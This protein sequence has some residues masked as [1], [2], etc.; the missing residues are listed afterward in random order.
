MWKYARTEEFGRRLLCVVL[1]LSVPLAAPGADA[2]LQREDLSEEAQRLLPKRDMVKVTFTDGEVIIGAI[3]EE[4]PENV[5][6]EETSPS[7]TRRREY[8]RSEIRTIEAMAIADYFAK[9][10]ARLRL[11]PKSS[12]SSAQYERAIRLLEEFLR[13]TP[14]HVYA[15][16]ARARLTAFQQ[17]KVNLD[18]GLKKIDGAWLAPVQAAVKRFDAFTARMGEMEKKFNGIA[19][20]NY[21][22]NAKAKQYY[23]RLIQERRDVARQL[24]E[25]INNRLPQLLASGNFDEAV[26]EAETFQKFWLG[27]VVQTEGG[28][29]T[30]RP[31][32]GRWGVPRGGQRTGALQDMDLD[33][34][35]RL[36]KRIMDAYVAAEAATPAAPPPVT[37]TNMVYIPGGYFLMGDAGASLG[38]DTHP[39]H[40]VHVAPF[41]IDA[42]EVSNAEY[43][44][45]VDHVKRTGDSSMEHPDA[46]PLK[47]HEPEGWRNSGLKQDDQPVVGADWFDAYVY[48]KWKGKR[49][50]TEAE[51]EMAARGKDG[52]RYAWGDQPPAKVFASTQSGRAALAAEI[53]R[54]EMPRDRNQKRDQPPP[55]VR[56]PDVA[57][58]VRARVP[59]RADMIDL[60]FAKEAKNAHGLHHM[61]GNA[62]EWLA[63][64]YQSD[65]Y[66]Q[67]PIQNPP[68][69]EK[70]NGHLIR[71]GSF[72]D[73][74]NA[75]QTF[76]RRAGTGS[77]AQ[78][79]DERGLAVVGF[80]CAKSLPLAAPP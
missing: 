45:F 56:L 51:W 59:K 57:W 70:G 75:V 11:H 66:M 61:C 55:A 37:E 58:P 79:L 76:Y 12:L 25:L 54:Q 39:P 42:H 74:D 32:A 26:A 27:R 2:P 10:V 78:G 1:L 68:G 49:L 62:A 47:N 77:W 69:P 14:D 24:P 73:A 65:Y 15:P 28:R 44:K 21:G 33:Y 38:A 67:S 18:R 41:L 35:P 60:A 17:E 72:A 13:L 36:Q 34:I 52:R 30:A 31:A 19:G 46:P 8:P 4:T 80:R 63:D 29:G 16:S 48:A 53:T 9:G 20:D 5:T 64:L 23:D 7:I 50:P 71:G 43:R 40:I 3:L 6:I 22:G